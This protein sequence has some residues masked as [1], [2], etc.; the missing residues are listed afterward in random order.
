MFT[1][2]TWC[3]PTSQAATGAKI[4]GRIS[5][6]FLRSFL[7]GD[8]TTLVIQRKRNPPDDMLN[9]LK[10]MNSFP[11]HDV[12]KLNDLSCDFAKDIRGISA[13]FHNLSPKGSVRK[14]QMPQLG[15]C[16]FSV[17]Q[18]STN[19]QS[20]GIGVPMFFLQTQIIKLSESRVPQKS[21]N[22]RCYH[23]N[24]MGKVHPVF[25]Q[26]QIGHSWW[27]ILLHPMHIRF[28]QNVLS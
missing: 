24:L 18:L 23:R 15:K 3:Y 20:F 2:Q 25:R 1:E 11:P 28:N 4:T 10:W 14:F 12:S 6:R 7:V 19:C 21:Q 26:N 17:F 9:Y 13:A 16:Y 5:T 8:P 27:Y 22:P